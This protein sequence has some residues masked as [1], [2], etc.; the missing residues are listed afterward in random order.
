MAKH[1]KA[2]TEISAKRS[3]HTAGVDVHDPRQTGAIGGRARAA[4]MTRE[5]RS[6]A[7][8]QAAKGHWSKPRATH[9]GVVKLGDIEIECAVLADKR[10]IINDAAFQRALG[11]AGAG[12]QTY[13]RRAAQSAIDQLPI[14][15]ALRNLKPF[16]PQGFSVSTVSYIMPG[17]GSATGVDAT[18]IP[19]V[20]SI[21]L[22]ARRA[23][24][25]MKQQLPTAE[26][27]EIINNALATVG[28]IALID[29]ATGY[30]AERDRHELQQILK[31]YVCPE[32]LPWLPRFPTEFFRET[33]R[34]MQWKYDDESTKTPR[35]VGKLINECIYKRLPAP[36]LPRLCEI[37]PVVNGHRRSRHH[38]HLTLETGIPHLDKQ[39]AVVTTLMRASTDR[40]M[41]NDLLVRAFPVRGDQLPLGTATN[42]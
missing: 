35:F 21:W 11:R 3:E 32:M 18:A 28:I 22:A 29:E 26:R 2:T 42:A 17:G 1:P 41:F 13:R 24:K 19:A 6:E 12:G 40:R 39:I 16:I 7:A 5:Q 25:L 27:A 4:N 9:T 15:L 37:N 38:Q 30:Q 14:Y 34:I 31:A 36:V 20:C 23:G 8:R 33:F 10:R